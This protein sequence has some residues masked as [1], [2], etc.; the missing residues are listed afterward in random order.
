[1]RTYHTETGF[2][3]VRRTTRHDT[4]S[5]VAVI[6]AIVLTVLFGV[7]TVGHEPMLDSTATMLQEN[8]HA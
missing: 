8:R 1:V 5:N 2:E 3:S 4:V 7:A 6:A